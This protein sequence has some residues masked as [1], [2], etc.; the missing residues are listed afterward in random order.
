MS[1]IQFFPDGPRTYSESQWKESNRGLRKLIQLHRPRLG[2]AQF[3]AEV[4]QKHLNS[5][6]PLLEELCRVTCPWCPEPCCIVNKVWIDFQDLL[7][8]HLI[9]QQI[10]PGQLTCGAGNPCRYLA[11]RGCKL[12][13]IIRP[14]ACTSYVCSTER[15]YLLNQGSYTQQSFYTAVEKIK[16]DRVALEEVFIQTV[17]RSR[18]LNSTTDKEEVLVESI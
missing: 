12:P 11:C 18:K 17:T 2:R 16:K 4:I 10:P 5:I 13:R 1:P 9:G 3:L 6:F 14:W 7:F 15:N 8:L